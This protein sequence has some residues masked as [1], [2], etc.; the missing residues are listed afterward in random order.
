MKRREILIGVGAL[1]AVGGGGTYGTLHRM[2]SMTD[3]DAA[4]A[5]T[6]AALSARPGMLEF[7]RMATL[8]PSGHN[9]QPWR[10]RI[11]K[12][13]I[14]IVPDLSRITPV[15]DPD[16]HHLYVAL[17][18]AAEN[19]VL[20]AGAG[21]YRGTVGFSAANDSVVTVSLEDGTAGDMALA[22]A[23]PKRQSTRTE[24]DGQQV[25]NADL[26]ALSDAAGIPG[27]DV[28][29]ITDR[30][31]KDKVCELVIEGNTTQMTDPAFMRELKHW[32]RFN[33]R[34]ALE[35]GDGLFSVLSGNPI[36]PTWAGPGLFDCFVSAQSENEIYASQLRSS[37]GIA[38]FVSEASG[39]EHWIQVGRSCERFALQATALGLKHAFV[40]QPVEVAAL[41]PALADLV[42]LGGR[43]PDILMR[44]GHAAERPFSARRS[45]QAVILP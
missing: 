33:P 6:R 40:N 18:C 38:V 7:I 21:G 23:I 16:N 17:G 27:V 15:V 45:P 32:L 24:F 14:E 28:V 22:D 25:S 1:T 5:T 35:T 13:H 41:R 34:E 10:F 4:M 11:G 43:R 26:Q 20:A 44:F 19:I 39:P 9:T 31:R 8:A 36:L 42:G 2:G 37:S 29:L 3:Y 12:D 30:L